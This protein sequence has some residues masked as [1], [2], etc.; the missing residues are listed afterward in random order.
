MN[1][2]ASAKPRGVLVVESWCVMVGLGFEGV[3][4]FLSLKTSEHGA[5]HLSTLSTSTPRRA[6]VRSPCL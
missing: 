3:V 2:V 5:P 6:G 1:S 4:P